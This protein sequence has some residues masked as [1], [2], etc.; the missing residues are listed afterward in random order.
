MGV[1]LTMLPVS[2]GDATLL[3][4]SDGSRRYTA[5]IDAGLH[6]VEAVSYL[7]S[8]GVFHLDLVVLSHP[9]MDHLGGL[10]AIIKSKAMSVGTIWCFDLA[11]LRDF[12]RN[13][14]IPKPQIATHE[15]VYCYRM[16]STLDKFSD[17][18]KTANGRDV[19][20]LQVSEG[21]RLS[22]GPML[23]EVLYPP[24][25]FYDA[26][27]SPATITKLIVNRKLPDEWN[28]RRDRDRACAGSASKVSIPEE[29][30]RLTAEME[31]PKEFDDQEL[32]TDF[33]DYENERENDQSSETI[34]WEMVGTLYN[35]LSIVVKV[36][37]L[38]GISGPTALFP[39]DLTDRT[40][41]VLRHWPELRADVF[42]LP[43]H[44]S[45]RIGCDTRFLQRELE[46]CYEFCHFICERY[47]LHFP[48][49]LTWGRSWDHR[50][51]RRWYDLLHS[52]RG[53]D[54]IRE[55]VH[56]SRV[57]VY[58]HPR[59]RLPNI[60]LGRPWPSVVANRTDRDPSFLNSPGNSANPAVLALGFEKHDIREITVL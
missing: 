15:V 10:L 9:D 45:N 6:D 55:L 27:R 3:M 8:I 28:D 35:N 38:G 22:L 57:L 7:Q 34:P 59:Y 2:A 39:G 4:A 11:F 53:I 17:I 33:S 23:F 54:L 21:Y 14:T 48:C 49:G 31:K 50:T 51:W 41:L 5:L 42:K 43:H 12:V 44:G 13:G 32:L 36:S 58:P 37:V 40:M 60:P 30:G 26:L 52:N 56:P 19:Q 18:L 16:L 24:Q 29:G 25:S 1:E 47:E 20:V 46:H